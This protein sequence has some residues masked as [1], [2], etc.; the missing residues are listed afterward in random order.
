MTSGGDAALE[1]RSPP[2]PERS[3]EGLQEEA[4][5][6]EKGFHCIFHAAYLGNAKNAS[7]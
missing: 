1:L 7:Y 2:H 5:R 3:G 6:S 4:S